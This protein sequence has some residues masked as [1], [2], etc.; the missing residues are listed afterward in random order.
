MAGQLP[1]RCQY[2]IEKVLM[3]ERINNEGS[4]C[5]PVFV[6]SSISALSQTTS[7][8]A[9][10]R[11]LPPRSLVFTTVYPRLIFWQVYWMVQ[12]GTWWAGRDVVSKTP[13]L[14]QYSVI[15]D[16]PTQVKTRL[17][18]HSVPHTLLI[19]QNQLSYLP[20]VFGSNIFPQKYKSY[21]EEP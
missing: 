12:L 1:L 21:A 2:V 19:S 4:Y 5:L 9:S 18:S 7:T 3:Y 15:S 10:D 17:L 13:R 20:S 14:S 16:T 6:S 11:S 8:S